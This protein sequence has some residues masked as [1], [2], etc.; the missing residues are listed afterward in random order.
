M[1][2]PI[3]LRQINGCSPDMSFFGGWLRIKSLA[4]F[5][6][7]SSDFLSLLSSYSVI[8]ELYIAETKYRWQYWYACLFYP[9]SLS[10]IYHV[11]FKIY[12][13]TELSKKYSEISLKAITMINHNLQSSYTICSCL[14]DVFYHFKINDKFFSHLLSHFYLLFYMC[15]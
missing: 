10:P 4:F 14:F 9:Y 12:I 13:V 15:I 3:I 5:V 2:I 6:L 8:V 7:D 11:R 1:A